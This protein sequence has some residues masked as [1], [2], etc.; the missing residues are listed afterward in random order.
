MNVCTQGIKFNHDR[1]V[2]STKKSHILSEYAYKHGK[3]H[4]IQEALFHAYFTDGAD[5]SSDN[6]LKEI[7]EQ[8]GLDGNTALTAISSTEHLQDFEEGIKEAKQKG[9]LQPKYLAQVEAPK[10]KVLYRGQ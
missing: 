6:V 1:N 3:Q 8:V 9:L 7:A 4:E 2:V 10:K 5:V